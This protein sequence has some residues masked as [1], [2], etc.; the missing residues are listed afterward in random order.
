MLVNAEETIRAFRKQRDALQARLD[1]VTAQW[2][3]AEYFFKKYKDAF[4]EEEDE[5]EKLQAKLDAAQE[6]LEQ[7]DQNMIATGYTEHAR[8]FVPLYEE[9]KQRA[10]AAAAESAAM[11]SEVRV[12][13]ENCHNLI[14]EANTLRQSVATLKEA[15]EEQRALWALAIPEIDEYDE[16]HYRVPFTA[17]HQPI[18]KID[19]AL[20]TTQLAAVAANAEGAQ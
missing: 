14:T 11:R 4:L 12:L 13:K 7:R 5:N 15:M 8:K 20:N 9:M 18:T 19:T 16:S 3:E 1:K 2:T 10:E 17:V 6:G